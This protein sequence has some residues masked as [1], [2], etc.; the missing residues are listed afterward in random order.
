MSE[1]TD[2]HREV[3]LPD[4]QTTSGKRGQPMN[5]DVTPV[6]SEEVGRSEDHGP[7]RM[8]SLLEEEGRQ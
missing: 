3:H 6:T 2:Y 4:L 5:I 8:A 1:I 7:V